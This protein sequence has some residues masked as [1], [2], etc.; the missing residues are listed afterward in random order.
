MLLPQLAARI[1]LNEAIV[2]QQI[3]FWVKN[4]ERRRDQRHL[5][6]GHW[7]VWNNYDEWQRDNFPFWHVGTIRRT[8]YSLTRP[9]EGPPL[10]ICAQPRGQDRTIWYRVNYDHPALCPSAQVAHI[11]VEV[12]CAQDEHLQPR[13]LSSCNRAIRADASSYTETP[14]DIPPSPPEGGTN[15]SAKDNGNGTPHPT[16]SEVRVSVANGHKP[17][18]RQGRDLDEDERGRLPETWPPDP[19]RQAELEA[20]ADLD[21]TPKQPAPARPLDPT[22]RQDWRQRLGVPGGKGEAP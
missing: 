22:F 12:A 10:V 16:R 5:H 17:R 4:A 14:T 15:G 18:R 3:H 2:L 1:G 11:Q 20:L 8:M 7:W 21:G 13:D 19:R 6:D 9:A